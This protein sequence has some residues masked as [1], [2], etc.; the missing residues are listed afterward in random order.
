MTS[1]FA[2]LIFFFAD[3]D[4]YMSLYSHVSGSTTQPVTETESNKSL[5]TRSL[6]SRSGTSGIH[7]TDTSVDIYSVST[8]DVELRQCKTPTE[9]RSVSKS[10]SYRETHSADIH[11]DVR[12]QVSAGYVGSPTSPCR[13]RSIPPSRQSLRRH[14]D[15]MT[16]FEREF[17]SEDYMSGDEGDDDN[18]VNTL[19]PSGQESDSL[20]QDNLISE[21][22]KDFLR[23]LPV[24]LSKRILGMLDKS[25]LTNCLC[26]SKHWR[27]LAEEVKQDYMV[28]QLMTEEIMLMQV[29]IIICI[30]VVSF[31]FSTVRQGVGERAL[32]S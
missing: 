13:T 12:S 22:Y 1:S 21:K 29:S 19:D 17:F 6:A 5:P 8:E 31:R 9:S 10:Q 14:P 7:D 32:G 11:S 2:F 15:E 30:T 23:C 24:H 3:D 20:I 26:L 25:S 18:F 28:H 27:V 16:D 4:E